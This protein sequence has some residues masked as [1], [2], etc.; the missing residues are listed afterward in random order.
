MYSRYISKPVNSISN[1]TQKAGF[2]PKAIIWPGRSE[3]SS[4]K[5]H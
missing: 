3:L 1:Q 5:K 4:D 2:W